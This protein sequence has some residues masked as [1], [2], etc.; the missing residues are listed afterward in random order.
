MLFQIL[1]QERSFLY[2]GMT[3]AKY[4]LVFTYSGKVSGFLNEFDSD[5]Y[6]HIDARGVALGKPFRKAKPV[7]IDSATLESEEQEKIEIETNASIKIE[8]KENDQKTIQD[9]NSI[10]KGSFVIVEDCDT[11]EERRFIIDPDSVIR[12]F[13]SLHPS[14]G[15]YILCYTADIYTKYS[16][17]FFT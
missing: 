8:E 13:E 6:E 16:V 9:P 4:Y 3:R 17:L 5:L 7:P 1:S 15:R 14:H 10:K 12:V 11:Y 2:V